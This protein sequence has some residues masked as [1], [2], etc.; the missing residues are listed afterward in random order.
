MKLEE[1]LEKAIDDATNCFLSNLVLLGDETCRWVSKLNVYRNAKA[2]ALELARTGHYDKMHDDEALNEAYHDF[3]QDC[4]HVYCTAYPG[5]I[6]EDLEK[7]Y[8]DDSVKDEIRD[9][10]GVTV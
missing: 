6:D 9:W 1:K 5:E 7:C 10:L 4:V 3:C 2:D 8:A